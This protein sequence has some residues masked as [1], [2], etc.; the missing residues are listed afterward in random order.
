MTVKPDLTRVWASGAPVANIEDPDVTTPG[1]FSA[2]WVAE[3]PTYQNF[4]YLQRM[5]TQALAHFNEE[6]VGIWDTNTTYPIYGISKGSDGNQYLS[7]LEQSANDPISDNGTN[8]VRI[9]PDIKAKT[10]SELENSSPTTTGL[11]AT[12][13]ERSNANY[14]LADESYI[15]LV[16]DI[17]ASNGRIWKL[18]IDGWM[19][20]AS[21]GATQGV[22]STTE[23]QAAFDRSE[24]VY[25]IGTDYRYTQLIVSSSLKFI[26]AGKKKTRLRTTDLTNDKITITADSSDSV[27]IADMEF[28]TIGTQTGGAYL[29]FDSSTTQLQN[30]K[31]LGCNFVS[32]YTAIYLANSAQFNISGC[33]F[34]S[35]INAGVI[36]EN[37]IEPDRGDSTIESNVFDAGATSGDAIVQISSGGLR[38]INNKFLNGEYHYRGNYNSTLDTSILVWTGNSSE[39]ASIAN[40]AFNGTSPTAFS[41]VNISG[42]NQFSVAASATGILINDPGYDFLRNNHIAGNIF[43]LGNSATAINAGRLN[44][45][46]IGRNTILGNGTLTTGIVL[47]SNSAGVKLSEQ[48]M[49][50]VNTE[51]NLSGGYKFTDWELETGQESDTTVNAFGPLYSTNTIIVA[52]SNLYPVIPD[53][54]ANAVNSNGAVSVLISNIT[55][56][57]FAMTILG[58]TNGVSVTANW[59]A[60][61]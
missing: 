51:Y 11:K 47:G 15:A 46:T 6:G 31:L 55:T 27:I 30:P 2:G 13:D 4:N 33:Y 44:N 61:L 10:V 8:W 24:W 37:D 32:P 41:Y 23:I 58:A 21:F 36:L 26:G 35:Y 1:K 48:S 52:F 5:M 22:D 25:A 43:N 29:R 57:G 28:G 54:K 34:V 56:T 39:Q 18:I 60:S 40:M 7:F 49:F 42:G 16:G 50:G 53:V 3:V 45:S 9:T 59:S 19:N 17:T 14:E 12:C 20:I 38:V